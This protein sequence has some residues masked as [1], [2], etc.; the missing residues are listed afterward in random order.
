MT[1]DGENL[2]RVMVGGGAPQDAGK[3]PRKSLRSPQTPP[4][5]P[6]HKVKMKRGEKNG[7]VWYSHK[8]KDGWCRGQAQRRGPRK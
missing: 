8:T 6:I 3:A 1:L 2:P 4:W 5:C 7:R